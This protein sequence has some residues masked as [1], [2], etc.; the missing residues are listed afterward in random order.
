MIGG[1][2]SKIKS[3]EVVDSKCDADDSYMYVDAG[4]IKDKD[5]EKEP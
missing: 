1:I 2:L 4:Y 5:R 3:E